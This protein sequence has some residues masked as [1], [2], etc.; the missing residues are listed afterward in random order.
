MDRAQLPNVRSHLPGQS[1]A[2]RRA[3]F[4]RDA[5]IAAARV[6]KQCLCRQACS[7]S[8]RTAGTFGV[9]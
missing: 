1:A 2:W 7:L 9:R 6:T 5:V 4:H 3:Q 8:A